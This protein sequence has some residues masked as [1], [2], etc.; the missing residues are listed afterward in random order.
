MT[1]VS[2]LTYVMARFGLLAVAIS[3]A[4][5]CASMIVLPADTTSTYVSRLPPGEVVW[6]YQCVG[7]NTV[8]EVRISAGKG[9]RIYVIACPE[10]KLAQLWYGE[11]NTTALKAFM[12]QE[13]VKVLVSTT[14][15]LVRTFCFDERAC[16]IAA[17]AN[18][19]SGFPSVSITMTMKVRLVP[20]DRGRL[21]ALA[22]GITGAVLALPHATMKIARRGSR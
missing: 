6:D 22:L 14:G 8:L 16:V 15:R 21:F 19:G 10:E 7:P 12:A 18:E 1:D 17:V 20:I 2:R 4:I 9:A 11:L 3:L 13:G 5:L